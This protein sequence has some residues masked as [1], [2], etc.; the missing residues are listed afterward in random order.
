MRYA[1]FCHNGRNDA[2]IGDAAH[3]LYEP[4]FWG[5]KNSSERNILSPAAV[6]FYLTSVP[7][8]STTVKPVRSTYSSS[9]ASNSTGSSRA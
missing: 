2:A 5:Q 9:G 7:P 1:S 4:A 3:R 8:H 6:L